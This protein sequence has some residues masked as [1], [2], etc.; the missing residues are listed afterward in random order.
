[1]EYQSIIGSSFPTPHKFGAHDSATKFK[2]C[3]DRWYRK[4][5]LGYH[6]ALIDLSIINTQKCSTN[7]YATTIKAQ[8]I[9]M[10]HLLSTMQ[11]R[12]AQ[13][14]RKLITVLNSA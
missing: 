1:M 9:I 5:L 11:Y 3:E 13:M 10:V 4:C 2:F 6:L 12:W 14:N 8:K 7:K